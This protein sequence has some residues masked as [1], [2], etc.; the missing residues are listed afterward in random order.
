[1][2]AKNISKEFDKFLI[3]IALHFIVHCNS[4]Y[5]VEHR[6]QSK[7]DLNKGCSLL[8]VLKPNVLQVC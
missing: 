7:I 2:A 3:C 6:V 5:R 8:T 4:Q 1:M